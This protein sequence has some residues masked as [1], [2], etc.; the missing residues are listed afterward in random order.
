MSR[1]SHHEERWTLKR[2][3]ISITGRVGALMDL[4]VPRNARYSGCAV[5]RKPR[6]DILRH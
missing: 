4:T 6:P 5:W 3:R 1:F 2:R